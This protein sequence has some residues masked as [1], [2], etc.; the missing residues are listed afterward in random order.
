ME[1]LE[2]LVF[3]CDIVSDLNGIGMNAICYCMRPFRVIVRYRISVAY[4]S[5]AFLMGLSAGGLICGGGAL[6]I[7]Q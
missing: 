7:Y 1:R 3:I 6:Y 4:R 5:K 2:Y